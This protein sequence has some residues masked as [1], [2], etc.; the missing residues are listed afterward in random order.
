MFSNILVLAIFFFNLI[1]VPL[2]VSF[3]TW[4]AAL[5]KILTMDNLRKQRVIV[6]D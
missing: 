3:F 2:K 5:G 6:V 4:S 1:K